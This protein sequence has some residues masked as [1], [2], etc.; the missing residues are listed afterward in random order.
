MVASFKAV[1]YIVVKG[2]NVAFNG[3]AI[4]KFMGMSTNI[5]D[6]YQQLIRKEKQDKIKK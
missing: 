6:H 1:D 2:R 5:K 3:E 4:N